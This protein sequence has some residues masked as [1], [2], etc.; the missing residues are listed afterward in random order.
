MRL[1]K[2]GVSCREREREGEREREVVCSCKAAYSS[3]FWIVTEKKHDPI[4]LSETT[5]H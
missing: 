5:N 3:G 1:G 2:V 4:L